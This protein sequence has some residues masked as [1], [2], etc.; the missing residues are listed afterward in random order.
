MK[1]INLNTLGKVLSDNEMKKIRGGGITCTCECDGYIF[2][3]GCSG[4]SI[5]ECNGY[6]CAGVDC[7]NIGCSM[8]M[9]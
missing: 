8:M 5:S 9:T 1:K 4:S 6:K 2:S 3:G 7:V